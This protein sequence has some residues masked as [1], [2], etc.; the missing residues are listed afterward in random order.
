MQTDYQKVEQEE[1]KR[2]D[3]RLITVLVIRTNDS[4][5]TVFILHAIMKINNIGDQHQL[6]R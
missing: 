3:L 5:M 6:V 1:E 4:L 2:Y